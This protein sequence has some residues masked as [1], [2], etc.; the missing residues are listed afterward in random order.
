MPRDAMVITGTV[1]KLHVKRLLRALGCGLALL[2]GA[3]LGIR[4]VDYFP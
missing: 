4:K 1:I 2:V 3:G